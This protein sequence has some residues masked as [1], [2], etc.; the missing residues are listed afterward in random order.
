LPA[1]DFQARP[2][3]E[4]LGYRVFGELPDC[5]RGATK[6]Y[7]SKRLSPVGAPAD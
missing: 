2:F 3:Y 4:R 1:D 6:Y 7:L 5:P